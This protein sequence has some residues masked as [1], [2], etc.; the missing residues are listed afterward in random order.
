MIYHLTGT[1]ILANEK[2]VVLE[3]GGVGYQ[4]FLPSDLLFTAMNQTG[5]TLSFWTYQ[6][7]RETALELFGFADKTSLEFFELL[8][9]TPGVG[10]RSA[11][12]IISIA[13]ADT[14]RRA[15]SSGDTSYL[16]K[17]SGIGR[18]TA[19]KI[20]I[21]LRDKLGSIEVETG[22]LRQEAEALEGLCSLGYSTQEAR[23]A[24]KQVDKEIVGV[25][26]RLKEALRVL[27]S[28]A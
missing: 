4:L 10:P 8:I 3:T 18:K 14:L 21:E 23:D 13:S 25:S 27:G 2:F 11:L 24:L 1:L 20:I 19:E 28:R 12:S 5:Q 15:I 6:A 7:V 22:D 17:V 16:T 9:E 26:A